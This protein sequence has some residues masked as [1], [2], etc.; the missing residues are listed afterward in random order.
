[1]DYEEI[2]PFSFNSLRDKVSFDSVGQAGIRKI[3]KGDYELIVGAQEKGE[4]ALISADLDLLLEELDFDDLLFEND[5][6]MLTTSNIS[7]GTKI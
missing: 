1:M 2:G 6:E 4:L 3:S 5:Q 7:L